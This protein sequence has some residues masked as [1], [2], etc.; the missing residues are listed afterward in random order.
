M[1]ALIPRDSS[2]GKLLAALSCGVA[3]SVDAWLPSGNDDAFSPMM[4]TVCFRNDLR[5]SS[6]TDAS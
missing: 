2:L 5:P 6:R 3:G 1:G 4:I